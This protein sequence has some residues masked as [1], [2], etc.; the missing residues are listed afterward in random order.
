MNIGIVPDGSTRDFAR[1]P[2]GTGPYRYRSLISLTA[3]RCFQAFEGYF[4]GKPRIQNLSIRII[5]DATTRALE[6]RKGTIDLLLGPAAVPPDYFRIL[7]NNPA[8]KTMTRT[9]SNYFYVA[10]NL[11]DPLLKKK[12]RTFAIAHAVRRNEIVKNSIS[13]NCNSCDRIA[14]ASQLGL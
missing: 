10:F 6:I 5:P 4:E 14:S 9:G 12:R 1:D 3:E 8:L 2:I 7:R 11:T 13:W